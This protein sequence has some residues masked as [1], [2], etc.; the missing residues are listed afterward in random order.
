MDEKAKQSDT[1][2]VPAAD[3][4]AG[5]GIAHLLSTRAEAPAIDLGDVT[6]C[7]KA[8]EKGAEG[9]LERLIPLVYDEL[10]RIAGRLMLAESPGT[11]QP[12]ALVHEAF[13]RILELR[14]VS[15]EDRG[16]FFAIAVRIMRRV[17]IDHAR[18]RGSWKRGGRDEHVP[19]QEA[20]DAFDARSAEYV[21]LDDAL[22]DLAQQDP[23]RAL[24]I[25]LRVFRGFD[26]RAN[27]RGDGSFTPDGYPAIQDG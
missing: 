17:I 27:R 3:A 24:I 12:T 6:L 13:M 1:E 7:L 14:K 11:L 23:Q 25:E 26:P 22:N 10:R 16:H 9:S 19:L 5:A 2:Q 20:L 15:V 4:T 21:A 18:A 8:W